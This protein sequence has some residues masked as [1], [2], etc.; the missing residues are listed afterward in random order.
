MQKEP[1]DSPEFLQAYAEHRQAQ[2][3]RFSVYSAWLAVTLVPGFA[4]LDYL[5]YPDQFY[6]FFLLRNAVTMVVGVLAMISVKLIPAYVKE[7]TIAGYSL[8]QVM[9]AYMIAVTEGSSSSYYAGMNIA[10]I[11]MGFFLPTV[12][13]ETFLFSLGTL[14]LYGLACTLASS[15]FFA[16]DFYVNAF[17]LVST[18]VIA[19]ASSFFFEQRRRNEFSL[20]FELEQRNAELDELNRQKTHFFANVSHELR[21]PLTLILAPVQEMLEGGYRLPDSVASRLAVVRDNS[22][23][24]LKLV[25][26]LLDVIR[27]EEGKERLESVPVELIGL[28]RGLV[29]SMDHLAHTKEIELVRSLDSSQVVIEADVRALEKI[30]VNLLNNA[31][32]FTDKGGRVTI[33]C[34]ALE[35]QAEIRVTDTGIGIP[36]DEQA[37]IFDRF[38]QVDG[39]STRRFRGTG[40]GLA[41]V[42]E[43]TELM[44]GVVEVNSAPGR[45]TCMTVRLPLA[46]QQSGEQQIA[47]LTALDREEDE[48]ERLHRLAEQRGGLE[49]EGPELPVDVEVTDVKRPT[50]LV[51]EDEPDMRR[52]L[53]DI[54]GGEYR[55]LQARTGTE[56]LRLA[57]DQAPDLIL[58]DLMLPEMDGLEVCSRIRET[59]LGPGPKIMLLTARVDEQAKITALN[60]GADDFLTKP[61]SSVEVKTRLRNL[62]T[63]AALERDLAEHN[64]RL[65]ATL[66]E[67]KQTQAQLIHSEKLNALGSLAAGLLHEINNPLNYSLTALQ[68]IRADANVR[69]NELLNEVI[70]DIDEGMQ[71]IRAIVSDLRAFAYPS[72]AETQLRF[73]FGDILESALRFTS[74]ELRGIDVKI[75]L[76]TDSSVLGSKSH[77]TQVLVNLLTNSAKAIQTVAEERKGEIRVTGAV[78]DGRFLVGVADNGIG[79]DE[80]TLERIF[81]PFFTTRDVGQGMGLGLSICHTIVANHGGRLRATS[82]PGEGSEL[83]FDLPVENGVC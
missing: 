44:G 1:N 14:I 18:A 77:I 66:S 4:V 9:L 26:D 38:H 59:G 78:K 21:T 45:G 20:S 83:V 5:V 69:E 57:L 15:P 61:F 82:R 2:W 3:L 16:Q 31:I 52:Y 54:L 47:E 46:T 71:R 29:D 40:L 56:G 34:R 13:L 35:Q 41:L 25:N 22:F 65:E 55:V 42:K 79:M 48:L 28:V 49:V 7:L 17:F 76:P 70:G 24:L 75:D 23:R 51:V 80:K 74:H 68:L 67:L 27:M 63:S 73:Q 30:L 8:I 72:E 32:K 60:H 36:H 6:F 33:E 58:L 37:H 12:L 81:D 19:T 50:L 64:K 53:V 43:L 62:R 10:L 11:G 39:S